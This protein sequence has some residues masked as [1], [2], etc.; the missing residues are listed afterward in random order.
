MSKEIRQMIDKVKNFNQ[1]I[2]E[3]INRNNDIKLGDSITRG[4]INGNGFVI[5]NPNHVKYYRVIGLNPNVKLQQVIMK[6]GEEEL[7]EIIEIDNNIV[8]KLRPLHGSL[9]YMISPDTDWSYSWVGNF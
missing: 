2:N 3:N 5:G 6:K 1:F 4:N 7:G 9:S 8:N